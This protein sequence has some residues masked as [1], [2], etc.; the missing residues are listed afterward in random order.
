MTDDR[1]VY[2]IFRDC[3]R[4]VES[5][6]RRR[7][8]ELFLADL[9]RHLL[10]SYNGFAAHA[11]VVR[12]PSG[13]VIIFPGQSGAGKSTLTAAAVQAGFEYLSDEAVCVEYGSN[14]AQPYLKPINLLAWSRH[15]LGIDADPVAELPIAPTHLGGVSERTRRDHRHVFSQPSGDLDLAP[16][17]ANEAVGK[18]IEMSFNHYR[19]PAKT[20][21]TVTGLAQRSQ[22]WELTYDDPIKAAQMLY[23]HFT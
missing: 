2:T 12:H 15:H 7:A 8:M 9:N 6:D 3:A 4:V 18:L 20:F 16:R 1:E 22:A 10:Y 5:S 14:L 17:R 23:E 11:G 19:E 21:Q 13:R